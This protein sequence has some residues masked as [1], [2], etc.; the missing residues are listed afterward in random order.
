MTLRQ[1]GVDWIGAVVA[2]GVELRDGRSHTGRYQSPWGL[3]GD[4]LAG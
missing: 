3:L 4:V 2:N 1:A